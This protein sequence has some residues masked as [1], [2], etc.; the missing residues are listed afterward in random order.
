VTQDS[1]DDICCGSYYTVSGLNFRAW[2][3]SNTYKIKQVGLVVNQ[4]LYPN[5]SLPV[6]G[7]QVD[8]KY[9]IN[10]QLV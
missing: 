10:I 4:S 7:G 8:L 2:Y 6:W 3:K 9:S 5:L 1:I